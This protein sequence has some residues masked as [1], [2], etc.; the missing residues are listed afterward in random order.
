M[1][2]REQWTG[3]KGKKDVYKRQFL[4]C[5]R[6]GGSSCDSGRRQQK[7][8]SLHW[9]NALCYEWNLPCSC[10]YLGAVSYTHLACRNHWKKKIVYFRKYEKNK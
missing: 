10:H 4:Y 8:G 7:R 3:F 6:H 1:A 2:N 9:R 5:A